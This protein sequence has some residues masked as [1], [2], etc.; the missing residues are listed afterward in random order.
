MLVHEQF[1]A[2]YELKYRL[3]KAR[4][5]RLIAAVREI[6]TPDEHND[7]ASG[8]AVPYHV[9]SLYF[10]NARLDGYR[11]K[12]AGLGIRAKLRLRTYGFDSPG[13][14]LEL[15]RK[16]GPLI[17][18]SRITLPRDAPWRGSGLDLITWLR[19][20]LCATAL[21]TWRRQR[22]EADLE[23]MLEWPGIRPIAVVAY[24]RLAFGSGGPANPRITFDTSV[25]GVSSDR[26]DAIRPM[27][28][29]L[30]GAV[31]LELKFTGRMP[32]FMAAL[33]R[34][35]QLELESISKYGEVIEG[36]APVFPVE[37]R[38]ALSDEGIGWPDTSLLYAAP[39][40]MLPLSRSGSPAIPE[41][42]S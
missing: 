4:S 34:G 11:G 8:S 37:R 29:V 12:L 24:E 13:A 25:R 42:H 30:S 18:K 26:L 23:A 31:V 21:P 28:S 20:S 9:R 41:A 33:I 19:R 39:R 40:T 10:D 6:L 7:A 5:E 3:T 38:H 32:G 22:P 16:R 1:P 35:F 27:R 14:Y 2:R 15:K 17:A 36:I